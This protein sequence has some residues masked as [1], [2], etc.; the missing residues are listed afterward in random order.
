MGAILTQV[1]DGLTKPIGYFSRQFKDSESRYNAYNAELCGLVAGLEHFMSYIKNSRV[2]A[3]TDHMPL[4]KAASRDKSTSDALLFKL[5]TMELSLIHIKG[6]EMPADALSRQALRE[7]KGNIPVAASTRLEALPEAMSDLHWKYEQSEDAQCKVIKDWITKQKMSLSDYMITITKLYGA[8][9]FIDSDNGLLYI[10]SG[11]TKRLPA[12]RLW[13][14]RT[15]S[16][17]HI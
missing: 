13:V 3:F 4:V 11:K 2:T 1:Q 9:S 16:L 6:Q 17:I 10:Y 12:K 14:P 15:L 8:S 5:S 7:T